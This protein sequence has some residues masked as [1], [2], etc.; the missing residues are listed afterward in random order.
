MFS[1]ASK[2]I[3]KVLLLLF[4]WFFRSEVVS[5]LI[6]GRL[7]RHE[8]C[9]NTVHWN[10]PGDKLVSGSDDTRVCIW[11]ASIIFFFLG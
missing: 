1:K 3:Q 2:A 8:G 11:D 9:V 4:F 7:E 5:C 10:D 6:R